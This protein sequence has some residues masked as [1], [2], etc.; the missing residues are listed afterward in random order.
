MYVETFTNERIIQDLAR[1][2]CN[3][4]GNV[5]TILRLIAEVERR[6]LFAVQGYSSLYGYCTE[7]L[8]YSEDEAYRRIGV[9]RAGL[10]FP[11]I[12]A[13]I[14]R[15]ELHLTG[16][17]RC[18][19]HLTE[20]NHRELLAAAAYKTKREIEEMLAEHNPVPDL[21]DLMEPSDCDP[22]HS[23]QPLAKDRFLICFTGSRRIRDLIER[24]KELTSHQRPR[25]GFEAVIEA[26]L[27]TYVEKLEKKKYKTT[28]RPHEPRASESEDPHYVPAH[29]KREVYLRDGGR[30]TYVG[31]NGRR[32]NARFLLE[33]DHIH[34]V[35]LGG[36]STVENVRLRCHAH[37]QL[38]AR[39]DYDPEYVALRAQGFRPVWKTRA[40]RRKEAR[41][42]K[43]VP[44]PVRREANLAYLN[45]IRP[46]GTEPLEFPLNLRERFL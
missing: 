43:L 27:E 35:G 45:A 38:T 36:K 2:R 3:E 19:A 8:G 7:E 5:A 14:E 46:F 37:N 15:G 13:M 31:C 16:A 12:I 23:V 39:E 24:A 32:C 29:V 26:A 30:C 10:R 42:T 20:E 6:R 34:P 44:E 41:R 18:A 28:D 21:P 22:R 40:A 1:A 11:L 4:R 33:F 9:A 17:A 25:P